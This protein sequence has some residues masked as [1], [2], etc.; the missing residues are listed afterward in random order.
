MLAHFVFRQLT[1]L[2]RIESSVGFAVIRDATPPTLTLTLAALVQGDVLVTWSATDGGSGLDV[3][4]CLL[5]V[6]EDEGAWQPFS[7]ACAGDDTYASQPGHTYTFRLS[8]SDNVGNANILEVE[9]VVP[10]V[11]KYYYA[12]G[13]RVAMRHDDVVYYIHSDHPS[14]SSGQALAA[15][16]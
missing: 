4:T 10:Y 5:E 13:Q 15:P 6:R 14:T 12:N 2:T 3:G 11:K 16:A 1:M 8:A 7:T 9:A